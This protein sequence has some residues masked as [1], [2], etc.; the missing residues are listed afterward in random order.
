MPVNFLHSLNV[1]SFLQVIRARLVQRFRFSNT[2][3]VQDPI[4]SS[5]TRMR[6]AIAKSTGLSERN[7]D[8]VAV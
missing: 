1:D 6:L 8:L 5:E 4:E 3:P 7:D 2:Y